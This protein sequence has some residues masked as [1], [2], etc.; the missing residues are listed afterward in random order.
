MIVVTATL[1]GMT[2]TIN[3]G[4]EHITGSITQEAGAIWSFQFNIKPNNAG[5]DLLQS[6][7]TII[8]A[9]NTTTGRT[10]F[11]GRVLLAGEGMESTGLVDKPVTCESFLGYLQ[12]S[13]QPYAAE[14]L[15]TLEQYI[16]LVLNNHNAQVEESKHIFRGNVNVDVANT[17][18]VYKGLQY[19]TSYQTLKSKLVDVY[20]GE[21]EIEEIDGVLYLNY[22]QQIG[23]TRATAI[24]LGRNMQ[25]ATREVSPLNIITRVIPLGAKLKI[26]ETDDD[27]NETERET[28]ER[29]TLEGYT[30][31]EGVTLAVPWVDD[32]EKIEHLGIICGTLDCSDITEQSNLYARVMEFMT[33]QNRLELSHTLTALDLKENGQEI[34]GLYCCDSYPVENELI[35]L[36]EVLRITKKTIDINAPHKGAIT[37]GEKKTTFSKLQANNVVKINAELKNLQKITQALGNASNAVSSQVTTLA[38]NLTQTI[39]AVVSQALASYVSTSDM[40]QIKEDI[41]T[42]ITQTAENIT[43]DFSNSITNITEELNGAISSEFT[44]LNA[45]IRY[46]MNDNGQPVV[47]L[48]AADSDIICRLLNNR[49]SFIENGVE[50]AYISDNQLFITTA[51]ITTSLNINNFTMKQRNNGNF[52]F[53]YREG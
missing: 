24:K 23:E 19:E 35:G 22:L 52:S 44:E 10:E 50:I 49:F 31:P 18:L 34:D 38:T 37:I 28:E 27:G 53:M 41:S 2:Q 13:I 15:Y 7:K 11:A 46:Y 39:S 6:R 32:T 43:I 30:T 26:T 42:T 40:E 16:D 12:D 20:G 1:D 14:D 9:V 17:G 4:G 47:E 29:L 51:T 48:G 33:K 25:A 21:L 36:N 3:G 5:Y 8:R 45:Y